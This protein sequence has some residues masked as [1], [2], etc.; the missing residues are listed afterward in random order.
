MVVKGKSA[1]PGVIVGSI[2][3]Y[4]KKFTI[5]KESFLKEEDTQKELDRYNDIKDLA[6]IELEELKFSL[7]KI[8][9]IKAEIFSAHQEIVDDITI[10]DEIPA[11][12]QN[13]LWSGDYAIFQVYQTV[14]T[15]LRQTLDPLISE[16]AEDFDDVRALLLRLWHGEI[17]EGLS[18][19]RDPVII[20][21]HDLKPSDTVSLD[22]I[23]FWQFLRR[24]EVLPHIQR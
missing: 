5:P 21:A 14:I 13:D 3:I 23:R 9:P 8:D 24:L 12:I 19:I 20:A 17:N 2:Y 16:R 10:N 7:Q 22:K 1:A 18:E 11:R 15:V 4:N 6:K